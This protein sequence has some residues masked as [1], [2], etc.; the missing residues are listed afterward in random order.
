[1][2]N[3]PGKGGVPAPRQ[4][5]QVA[6]SPTPAAARTPTPAAARTSTPAAAGNH[7]PTWQFVLPLLFMYGPVLVSHVRELL[8]AA[9]SGA[10]AGELFRMIAGWLGLSVGNPDD[11]GGDDGGDV[12]GA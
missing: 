9:R 2:A 6:P 5:G 7:T 3:V 12:D 8:D 10:D 11:N 1:M 4:A